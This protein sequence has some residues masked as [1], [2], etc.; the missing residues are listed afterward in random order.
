MKPV[1][2]WLTG[3]SGAGKTTISSQ[4][5]K[6]LAELG[7]KVEHLDG[8]RIRAI[9]PDTGFTA[10]DRKFHLQ[11]IGL[12]AHFLERNGVSVVASFI[13][14]QESVRRQIRGMCE[15]FVEV[16]VAT[17]LEVCEERDVKGLYAKA[18]RGEIP[19]F[20]G[21]DE[22]Y[23]APTNPEV[24]LDTANTSVEDAVARIMSEVKRRAS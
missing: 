19:N 23:E 4:L 2:I 14:P 21:I 12:I 20:T 16:H 13:S 15:N 9:L 24:R 7:Q 8:D 17:P 3:L 11:R 22:A 18:R 10:A 6:A 5:V 1:V